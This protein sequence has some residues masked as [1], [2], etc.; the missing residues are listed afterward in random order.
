MDTNTSPQSRSFFRSRAFTLL[1][2]ILIE[3]IIVLV[4]FRAGMSVGFYKASSSLRWGENYQ[5]VFGGPR[6]GRPG[7]G[8]RGDDNFINA[9]GVAGQ[10]ISNDDGTIV[11][12]SRDNIERT[13]TTSSTTIIRQG[14]TDTIRPADLKANDQI[15]VLGESDEVGQIKAKF[16][17]IF[18][19]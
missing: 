19:N 3:L 6:L 10:V 1:L 4:V 11:I 5:R 13:I 2:A 7:P 16:I 12:R 14:S 18:A 8:W 17:R 15:V 9:H